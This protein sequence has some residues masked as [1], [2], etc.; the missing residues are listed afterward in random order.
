M[1]RTTVFLWLENIFFSFQNNPKSLDPSY[2]MG[3]DLGDFLEICNSY[4]SEISLD[5]VICSHSREGK[6][7]TTSYS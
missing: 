4:Y 3:L 5:L 6:K 1:T 7:K 2:K